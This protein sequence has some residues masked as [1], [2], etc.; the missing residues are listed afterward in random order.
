MLAHTLQISI[1][2]I[3]RDFIRVVHRFVACSFCPDGVRNIFTGIFTVVTTSAGFFGFMYTHLP[4]MNPRR[5][6]NSTN[7]VQAMITG[8][9]SIIDID[10]HW[11]FCS[12]RIAILLSR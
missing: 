12:T 6:A 1:S 7:N 2:S 4:A 8:A 5:I 9:L 10:T 11:H 3:V